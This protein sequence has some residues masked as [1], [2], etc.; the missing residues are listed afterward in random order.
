MNRPDADHAQALVPLQDNGPEPQ[1]ARASMIARL[2]DEDA[3]HPG[4]VRDALL[5][6]PREVLMPQAYVRRT[7]DDVTPPE[8]TL[9]DWRQPTDRAELL[10]ILHCGESVLTQHDGEPV[11][12][13]DAG[14]WRRGGEITSLSSGMTMTAGLMEQLG[15]RPGLRVLNLG[16]GPGVTCA[17]ASMICGAQHVVS[18]DSSV[19]VTEAARL[20]LTR[21]GLCPTLV[22]GQGEDGWPDLAPYERI[23]ASYAVPA[24]PAPW[25]EQL[26][27][28]GFALAHITSGS[29]SWPALAVIT[30]TAAGAATGELRPARYGHRA[31]HG[32]PR[33]YLSK[34]F[35]DRIDAG[36]GAAV[37]R[38]RQ[39]VPARTEQGFWLAYDALHPGA[40]R[41]AGVEHLVLGAP[42][43]GSW[44]TAEPAPDGAWTVRSHGPRDIWG[45]IQ[46]AAS[47]WRAA[48]SPASYRIHL[49]PDG[50]QWVTASS[51]AGSGDL[52][53]SLPI[54]TPPAPGPSP[55]PDTKERTNQELTA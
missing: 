43:C 31:G 38:S 51:V 40:V 50:T 3:L 28:G 22:T 25:L 55:A 35:R 2:E 7:E 52:S 20:H 21:L 32:L 6:I 16:T 34:P 54:A 12:G 15:L 42:A 10:D 14:T 45:E 48:G 1:A 18:L 36:E 17:V 26:A 23:F 30:K 27:P 41:R 39:E 33:L 37:T 24:I 4:P 19:H 8:W 11:L 44:M 53:W 47:R 9:L 49:A 13:R 46:D 29:P 5:A